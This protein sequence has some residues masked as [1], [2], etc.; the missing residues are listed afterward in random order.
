MLSPLSPT[1]L[2]PPGPL[3]SSVQPCSCSSLSRGGEPVLLLC[4]QR[5]PRG[6]R[7]AGTAPAAA[8]GHGRGPQLR[9]ALVTAAPGAVAAAPCAWFCSGDKEW[10]SGSG[11]ARL[12][13]RDKP[14]MRPGRRLGAAGSARRAICDRSELCHRSLG[15]S[16]RRGQ[17]SSQSREGIPVSSFCPF[18]ADKAVLSQRPHLPGMGSKPPPVSGYF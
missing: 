14:G 15:D 2:P 10:R 18:R 9:T 1:L 13:R 8:M 17:Q 6:C 16:E 3:P 12:S 11:S 5:G 4:Q 7:G